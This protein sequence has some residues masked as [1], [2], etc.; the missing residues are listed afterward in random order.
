MYE[1]EVVG[2]RGKEKKTNI[3]PRMQ[4]SKQV[5]AVC[6]RRKQE[7]EEKNQEAARERREQETEKKRPRHPHVYQSIPSIKREIFS[8]PP[9]IN[10][11]S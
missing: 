10:S 1:E 6:K 2:S 3:L 8:F 4:V 5:L 9:L 7:R 11:P